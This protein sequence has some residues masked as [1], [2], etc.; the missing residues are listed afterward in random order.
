MKQTLWTTAAAIAL[1]MAG[2]SLALAQTQ[3]SPYHGSPGYGQPSYPNS[4]K[5]SEPPAPMPAAPGPSA[6]EERPGTSVAT[7]RAVHHLHRH[8]YRVRYLHRHY[9]HH[10][11]ARSW[12]DNVADQLNHEEL[13]RLEAGLPA[14]PA[15]GSSTPPTR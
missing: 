5:Y 2:S 14:E 8:A 7:H 3:V 6:A 4:E 12:R 10:R 15:V 11:Y 1:L 9:A 13:H